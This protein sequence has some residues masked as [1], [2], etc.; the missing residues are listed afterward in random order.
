MMLGMALWPTLADSQLLGRA[1]QVHDQVQ[2]MLTKCA[3]LRDHVVTSACLLEASF[4]L[5]SSEHRRP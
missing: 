1:D 2:N 5:Q 4:R 3:C